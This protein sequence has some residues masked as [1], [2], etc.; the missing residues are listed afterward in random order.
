MDQPNPPTCGE[1]GLPPVD[2]FDE[3][4]IAAIAKALAHPTRVRI[5]EQFRE[6][7]PFMVHEIVAGCELAQSTVSEHLRILRTAN[8]VFATQD[9]PRTWYCLRRSVL[10]AFAAAVEDLSS[11]IVTIGRR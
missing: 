3:S 9:G 6:H 4:D 10:K 7:R 2:P 8:V 5:I 11:E 1:A